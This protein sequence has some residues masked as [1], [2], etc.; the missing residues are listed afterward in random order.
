M[1]LSSELAW[2]FVPHA[3]NGMQPFFP[4]RDHT[5]YL[6][7]EEDPGVAP[8][9]MGDI[10]Q[11]LRK[12]GPFPERAW[13][14]FDIAD[15]ADNSADYMRRITTATDPAMRRFLIDHTGKLLPYSGASSATAA[16][17][18]IPDHYQQDEQ[19]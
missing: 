14:E 2:L 7:Y 18:P 9:D 3:G 15:R 12:E 17:K 6:F 1:P 16:P 19:T 11:K 10:T 8:A 5:N 13:S 4:A